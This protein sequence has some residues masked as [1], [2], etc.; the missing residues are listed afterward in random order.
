MTTLA[1]PLGALLTDFTAEVDAPV[2]VP[3]QI[4]RI[5]GETVYLR[6]AQ[7][8]IWTI[9]RERGTARTSHLS[10]ATLTP[11]Y[12]VSG[13]SGSVT[14]DQQDALDNAPTPLSA[15]NPVASVADAGGGG[16][17]QW[18]SIP[19]L[20]ADILALDTTPVEILPAPGGRLY[21]VPLFAILHY[22]FGT[23]PFSANFLPHIGFGST[24]A[25]LINASG[26]ALALFG[27]NGIDFQKKALLAQTA[28]AYVFMTT[29]YEQLGYGA[30]LAA[31]MED[32]PLSIAQDSTGGNGA[33]TGGDGTLTV[34]VLYSVIDGAP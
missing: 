22:R 23:T 14:A 11:L 3:A 18:H 24:P 19:L 5:D 4:Y 26:D 13:G 25:E 17:V 28:D 34:R 32:K 33:V 6:R 12:P 27:N 1:E 29:E 10:G 21:Y 31:S 20:A 7:G 30:W 2:P 9:S 8:T 15:A 16:V